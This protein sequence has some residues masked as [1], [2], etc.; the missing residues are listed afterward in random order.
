G[1]WL[2][3]VAGWLREGRSP[4]FFIHTPDNVDAPIL[5]RR[6]HDQVRGLVPELEPLPEPS[7]E[8]DAAGQPT[9]F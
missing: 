9:L 3:V 6:F 5:A 8:T 7:F 1:P 2:E 4:T